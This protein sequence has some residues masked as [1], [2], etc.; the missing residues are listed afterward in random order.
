[1]WHRPRLESSGHMCSL[2]PSAGIMRAGQPPRGK[3]RDISVF[4]SETI[5][6]QPPAWWPVNK[7]SQPHQLYLAGAQP[8]IDAWASTGQIPGSRP[9]QMNPTDPGAK[10]FYGCIP[11]EFCD[12]LLDNWRNPFIISEP[13]HLQLPL[14]ESCW[15]AFR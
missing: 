9:D 5:L 7:S 15:Q 8:A 4:L 3:A 2:L 12:S 14:V 1:M 13:V 6:D 10:C 11:L